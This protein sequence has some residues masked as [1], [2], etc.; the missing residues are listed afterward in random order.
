MALRVTSPAFDSGAPI[1]ARHAGDGEDVSPA[2][3]W[4]P[5]PAGTRELCLLF[6]D[7]DAPRPQPWVHWLVAGIPITTFGIA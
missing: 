5:V 2:L 3:A 6:E 1:P 7:A 4:G